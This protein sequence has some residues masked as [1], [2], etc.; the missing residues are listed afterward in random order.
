ME[1]GRN[2]VNRVN[3]KNIGKCKDC[4][5]FIPERGWGDFMGYKPSEC[6]K[7]GLP[8]YDF[9]PATKN[10]R[11]WGCRFWVTLNKGGLK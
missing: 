3:L 6:K 1:R 11:L 9:F 10:E 5:Y 4:A 8:F 2:K 7:L